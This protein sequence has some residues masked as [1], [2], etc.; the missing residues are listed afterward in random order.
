M[1]YIIISVFVSS[2]PA[3]WIKGGGR[4]RG[5]GRNQ[6]LSEQDKIHIRKL[7]GPPR[8]LPREITTRPTRETT[9]TPTTTR[10]TTYLLFMH[11]IHIHFNTDLVKMLL[12]SWWLWHLY[13]YIQKHLIS[14]LLTSYECSFVILNFLLDYRKETNFRRYKISR[15]SQIYRTL[16]ILILEIVKLSSS[17]AYYLLILS[18]IFM[19]YSDF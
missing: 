15:I 3:E 7:Y 6:E 12:L 14:A 10:P 18:N 5:I 8:N 11:Y 4:P 9:T 2:F 13:L 16:K 17:T 1:T 19:K